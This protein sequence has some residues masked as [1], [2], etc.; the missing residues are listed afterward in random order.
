MSQEKMNVNAGYAEI[1]M[2]QSYTF[3]INEGAVFVYEVRPKA[4]PEGMMNI[5]PFYIATLDD[6][7]SE[8]AWGLGVSPEDAIKAALKEWERIMGPENNPFKKVVE[9]E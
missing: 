9:Q 3:G 5:D 2:V 8:V 4:V 7:Y 1:E 6:G